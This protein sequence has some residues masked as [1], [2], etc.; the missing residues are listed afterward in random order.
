MNEIVLHFKLGALRYLFISNKMILS[1]TIGV[2]R[3]AV[4]NNN[5]IISR[6]KIINKI[7]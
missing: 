2:D 6:Y 5:V 1:R 7:A 4:I 3:S